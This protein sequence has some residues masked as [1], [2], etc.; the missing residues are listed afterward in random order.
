M[1]RS[2]YCGSCLNAFS[3]DEDTC[4]NL[5]CDASRPA[6]GWGQ[7]LT[8]GEIFDRYY[9]IS[10]RIAIAGSGICYRAFEID[11]EGE[12]HGEPLAIKVLYA[13]RDSGPYLRRLSAEAQILQDLAHP[14][15][16]ECR[17]FVHRSGRPPYLITRFE[18]G[19]SLQDHIRHVGALPIGVAA[20]ITHQILQGLQV[21]HQRGIVHRDLKPQNVLIRAPVQRTEVPHTLLADFGIAKVSGSLTE[22]LTQVGSFVGTPEF[23]APEQFRGDAP[24]LETDL[25]AVGA[26]LYFMITAE[27]PVAYAYRRDPA[28]CLETLLDALPMRLPS[29]IGTRADRSRVEDLLDTLMNPA[30]EA[31]WAIPAILKILEGLLDI[32]DEE[33]A[34]PASPEEH[35][36]LVAWHVSDDGTEPESTEPDLAPLPTPAPP[37]TQSRRMKLPKQMAA[38]TPPTTTA[39]RDPPT[40]LDDLFGGSSAAP[41]AAP[42][43][44]HSTLSLDDLFTRAPAE[45]V[46]PAAAPQAAEASPA[47]APSTPRSWEPERPKPVPASLPDDTRALLRLLGEVSAADRPAVSEAIQERSDLPTCLSTYAP[48]ADDRLARGTSLC[49]GIQKQTSRALMLRRMLQDPDPSVRAC[50]AEAIGMVCQPAML[51]SLSRLIADPDAQVRASAARGLTRAA[52]SLDC[53]PTVR[54]WLQPLEYDPVRDVRETWSMAIAQLD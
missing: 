21:A 7:L 32:T 53:E 25:F 3:Q 26:L 48:G 54:R 47:P 15:I 35:Q 46:T 8:R 33:E 22:G 2:F 4:P 27:P 20:A 40:S 19:G 24:S 17:G 39:L 18:E 31:R 30:R 5:A 23:A 45:P 52:K 43:Q 28:H 38:P 50:A 37:P 12:P 13:S 16:V 6:T 10:K 51:S 42:S 41:T 11:A 36:T 1:S 34:A 49:I 9:A 44:A 29:H 14:H